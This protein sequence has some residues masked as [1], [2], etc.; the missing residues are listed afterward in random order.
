MILIANIFF[1]SFFPA[2]LNFFSN[3]AASPYLDMIKMFVGCVGWIGSLVL[4]V[5]WNEKRKN[6]KTVAV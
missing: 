4:F 5:K 1:A 6:K 2:L 3:L